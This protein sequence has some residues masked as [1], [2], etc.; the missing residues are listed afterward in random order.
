MM[1]AA[2]EN[3]CNFFDNAEVYGAGRS[4]TIMGKC[5]KNLET[6]MGIKRSD[7]VISTKIYWG[8]STAPN[9]T[10]LSRKHIMEAMDAALERLQLKYVDL[11]FCHRPDKRTPMKEIVRAMSDLVTQGKAFYWGTSEWSAAELVEA[12]YIAKENHLHEPIM[13]QCQYNLLC[14]RRVE[15]EYEQLYHTMKLGLTTWS[16]LASGLLSGKYKKENLEKPENLPEGVRFN[17]KDVTFL[18]DNLF[19]EAGPNGLEITN[20]FEIIEKLE[21]LKPICSKLNCSV[22]QLCIAWCVKNE[23]VSTVI[24]GASRPEQVVENFKAIGI[25]RQLDQATMNQIDQIF[26]NKPQPVWREFRRPIS[27]PPNK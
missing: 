14:R 19:S 4:E 23:N 2:I 25:S 15:A 8:Q 20:R 16:P 26:G 11:I 22:A 5:L 12:Y 1:R 7:L 3:G 10:G 6:E 27:F 18:K 9:A 17:S 21:A 24:T 13:D